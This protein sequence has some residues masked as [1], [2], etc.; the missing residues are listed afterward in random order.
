M[1]PNSSPSYISVKRASDLIE[2]F[3]P[4][5]KMLRYETIRVC[6]SY[7]RVLAEDVI[8][9]FDIPTF[10]S[11]HMDGYAINAQDIIQASERTPIVLRLKEGQIKPDRRV[12]PRSP[13]R[14]QEALRIGTGGFL[15]YGADS[16]VPLEETHADGKKNKVYIMTTL[17]AGSFVHQ[18]GHDI[19]KGQEVMKRGR[20]LRPQD[21]GL[22]ELLHVTKV[23]VFKRPRV[24]IISTGSE[25]TNDAR[26][27]KAGKVLDTHSGIISKLVEE[28][29]GLSFRMG[30][31]PDDIPKIRNKIENAMAQSMDLVLT[32]GGSSVGTYDLVETAI[33]SMGKPTILF[34]GV[35]LDRGR[36]TGVA[37]IKGKPIIIM[38]GPIQGAVNAFIV[39][40]YP[41][42]KLLSG[43]IKG[44]P[45]RVDARMVQEWNA[46]KRFPNFMKIIYVRL[47]TK[48]NGEYAADTIV[49]ETESLTTLTMSNGYVLVDERTTHIKAGSKVKVNLLPGLS[50]VNDHLANP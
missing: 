6:H 26:Y 29:G 1:I 34:H 35:K 43:H 12:P 21:I 44:K 30:I 7:A 27:V 48:K 47:R 37:V 42:I 24:A 11:S 50:Y 32:L 9:A 16:V 31:T 20:I 14:K 49:G 15:P 25:L 18:R 46:R 5:N 28:L 17:P 45:L 40:A 23:K 36:V 3:V 8:S 41:I 2:R 4:R 19:K 33:N 22:L 38:P 39:F 13:L 10:D